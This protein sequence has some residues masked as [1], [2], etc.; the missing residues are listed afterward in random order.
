MSRELE[1]SEALASIRSQIPSGVNLIVVTKTYPISDIEILYRLGERNF[2]ENRDQEGAI[3]SAALPE[4]A[5]WHFQGA[6]Q[7]NKLR[8]IVKWSDYIHSL[9][10]LDHARKI[11]QIAASLGKRCSVFIQ[12]NLDKTPTGDRS[13]IV[14][15]NLES[16]AETLLE[17]TNIEVVGVMGVAP[18][19]DE[20]GPA[21]EK[22]SSCASRIT[23]V[24]PSARYISAGMSGDFKVALQYGATHIRIGSSI[25]GLR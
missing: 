19:N 14:D 16:F 5:V 21:F 20:P 11:N 1:I 13:G 2:G 24:I 9:D 17:M 6:L 4:D 15:E 8:S 7:S 3:K 22:L 18:L 10:D 12:I 25:L 23:K